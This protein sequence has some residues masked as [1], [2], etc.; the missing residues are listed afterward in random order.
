MS[1]LGR[2]GDQDVKDVQTA[3]LQVLQEEP[4]DPQK[5]SLCGGSHG[6]LISCHLIGQYPDFYKSCTVR[7][8]VTNITTMA[9]STDIPDWCYEESGYTYSYQTLPNGAHL[10][11]MLKK[12]PIIYI[13]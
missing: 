7:N 4:V 3:V 8:P 2:I 9:G 11:E 13:S 5:V 12:S 1:L 10:E 6:G